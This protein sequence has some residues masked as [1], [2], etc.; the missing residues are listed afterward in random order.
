MWVFVLWLLCFWHFEVQL[1]RVFTCQFAHSSTHRRPVQHCAQ[2]DNLSK[3]EGELWRRP[4]WSQQGAPILITACVQHKCFPHSCDSK[5]FGAASGQ[6]A[7]ISVSSIVYIARPFSQEQRDSTKQK[8][9]RSKI[10]TTTKNKQH[11][12]TKLL[13]RSIILITAVNLPTALNIERGKIKCNRSTAHCIM[14]GV[15]CRLYFCY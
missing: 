12:E 9:W 2:T 15:R 3:S 14:I 5:L 4:S 13:V 8:A 1:C 6:V 10:K 7:A 11:N